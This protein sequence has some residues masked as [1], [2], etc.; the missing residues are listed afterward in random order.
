M[1]CSSVIRIR[2]RDC[3]CFEKQ[4]KWIE[5]TFRGRNCLQGDAFINFENKFEIFVGEIATLHEVFQ[6]TFHLVSSLFVFDNALHCNAYSRCESNKISIFNNYQTTFC[7][8]Y[9]LTWE[10]FASNYTSINSCKNNNFLDSYKNV[11]ISHPEV[12]YVL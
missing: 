12:N 7:H 9:K 6:K 10:L 1:L 8:I 2:E 11:L 3:L 4:K 5:K